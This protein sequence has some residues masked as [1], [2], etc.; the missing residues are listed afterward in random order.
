MNTDTPS[1]GVPIQGRDY[2]N[3]VTDTRLEQTIITLA[4]LE[5]EVTHKVSK[6]ACAEI[7]SGLQVQME[8]QSK[9]LLTLLVMFPTVIGAAVSVVIW[10]VK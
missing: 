6:Q 4:R 3:G 5:G 8:R 10:V 7:R 1:G 9:L 2:H